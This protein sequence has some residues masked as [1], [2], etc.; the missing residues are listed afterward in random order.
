MTTFAIFGLELTCLFA[1]IAEVESE[2]GATSENVY[3]ISDEY[4]N[5]LNRI[6]THHYPHKCK[7][8]R[9]ASQC[10]MMDYWRYYAYRY[11]KRTGKPITYEVLARIH[12]GGPLGAERVSTKKYWTKIKR[13]MERGK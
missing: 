9:L 4:I 10:M 2:N 13:V 8:D 7:Y 12:N 3:Q 6:Y 5:D 1:A 11:S